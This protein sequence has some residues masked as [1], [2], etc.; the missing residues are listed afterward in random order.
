[1]DMKTSKRIPPGTPKYHR[2]TSENRIIIW[3]LKKEGK[4]ETYIAARIGCSVST[5]S[6]ELDRNK[7]KKGYRHKKAQGMTQHRIA[8]KAA[9]RRKFT[10]KMWKLFKE[11]PWEGRTPQMVVGRCRRDGIPMVCVETLYQE[12]YRRQE[13]V[14]KGAVE[15]RPAPL[16][17]RR[18]QRKTRN[19]DAKKYRNAGRGKIPGRVDIDERPRTVENRARV[20]HWEGDLINGLKGTY[21]PTQGNRRQRKWN[22]RCFAGNARRRQETSAARCA[23]CAESRR[24]SP[25]CRM[26]WSLRPSFSLKSR[27]RCARR[28]SPSTSPSTT[29]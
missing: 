21:A 22:R 17:K 10:D 16:P 5:I 23:A 9:K 24:T 11:K 14:R 1:M 6:R 4:S 27:R 13:L 12:Y 28:T 3:T 20:G 15:G 25:P 29:S 18:K 8:V 19:R 7:G 2:L 26:S